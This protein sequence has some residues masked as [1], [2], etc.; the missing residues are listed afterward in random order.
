[1]WGPAVRR[2]MTVMV[3]AAF[4]FDLCSHAM[5]TDSLETVAHIV[6]LALTPVFLLS[7]I[8]ALLNVFSTRLGRVADQADRLSQQPKEEVRD[9]RLRILCPSALKRPPRRTVTYLID[10]ARKWC[11]PP[12]SRSGP[13][14]SANF[15]FSSVRW[16]GRGGVPLRSRCT[17]QHQAGRRDEAVDSPQDGRPQPT[18]IGGVVV[19]DV[20]TPTPYRYPLCRPFDNLRDPAPRAAAMLTPTHSAYAGPI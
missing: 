3:G 16:R 4:D 13:R 11:S 12:G 19:F 17:A 15:P 18:G 9:A 10:F 20:E 2:M 7:G 8:A 6:Q 5:T 1:V 14:P